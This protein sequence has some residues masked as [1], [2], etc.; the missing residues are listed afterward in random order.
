MRFEIRT[1]S[2]TLSTLVVLFV[3]V[4][5]ASLDV[6]ASQRGRG[7]SHNRGR[8]LG[9][10]RGRRVGQHRRND[11]NGRRRWRREVRRDRREDRRDRRRHRR[12]ERRSS[13]DND[14]SWQGSLSGRGRPDY[15]SRRFT[16]YRGRS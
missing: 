12:I 13:W 4:L 1:L 6:L 2:R 7:R 15:R 16:Q 10:E 8:H 9:W 3:L 14:R 11:N 5:G